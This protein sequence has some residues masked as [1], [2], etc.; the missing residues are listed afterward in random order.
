VALHVGLLAGPD[1][2]AARER[3]ELA[4]PHL[5]LLLGYGRS[6]A[7]GTRIEPHEAVMVLYAAMQV[8]EMA[9]D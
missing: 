7:A 1:E 2:A 6:A 9:S 5:Q 8:A 3:A 4:S